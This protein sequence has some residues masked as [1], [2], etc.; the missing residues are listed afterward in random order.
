MHLGLKSDSDSFDKKLREKDCIQFLDS[1]SALQCLKMKV[2][3]RVHY[4]VRESECPKLLNAIYSVSLDPKYIALSY[5][6]CLGLEDDG[7][8]RNGISEYV[9]NHKTLLEQIKI[10]HS[11]ES[12][13]SK[14]FLDSSDFVSS[15][16]VLAGIGSEVGIT[17]EKI[18]RNCGSAVLEHNLLVIAL[19][20]SKICC[21]SLE[22][23]CQRSSIEAMDVLQKLIV[24]EK[25]PALINAK[26]NYIEF[27][28]SQQPS[29]R[30]VELIEHCRHLIRKEIAAKDL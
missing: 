21:S 10:D 28:K 25:I 4:G 15:L 20:Y 5:V 7:A 3:F 29:R 11:I 19:S 17:N 14:K 22:S 26:E 12:F 16:G 2:Q 24:S 30:S 1:N 9:L 13:L 6:C 8:R 27:Q 18:E 23:L